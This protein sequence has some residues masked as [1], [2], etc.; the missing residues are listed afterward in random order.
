[1]S[2]YAEKSLARHGTLALA[3]VTAFLHVQAQ[4]LVGTPL[5]QRGA[6]AGRR[7]VRSHVVSESSSKV[8]MEDLCNR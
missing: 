1:M 4:V 8:D 2:G 7:Y 5:V 6:N 3:S